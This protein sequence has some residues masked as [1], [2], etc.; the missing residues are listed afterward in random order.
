MYSPGHLGR[1]DNYDGEQA[2]RVT[3]VKSDESLHLSQA[4]RMAEACRT[5]V[6]GSSERVSKTLMET[7]PGAVAK[8]P[9]SDK[10]IKIMNDVGTGALPPGTGNRQFR[11]LTGMDLSKGCEKLDSL[12][13]TLIKLDPSVKPTSRRSWPGRG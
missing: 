7:R 11:E 5:S 12:Q 8:P 4:D 3:R 10:A 2:Y 6:K 13:E 9:F 1:Y